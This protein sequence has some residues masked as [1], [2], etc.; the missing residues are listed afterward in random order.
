MNQESRVRL[1]MELF[2]V[3]QKSQIFQRMVMQ[4]DL[5]GEYRILSKIIADMGEDPEAYI[6][7][8]DTYDKMREAAQQAAQAAQQQQPQGQESANG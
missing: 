3:L 2:E 7:T 4:Q 6:G 5:T 1:D 8:E